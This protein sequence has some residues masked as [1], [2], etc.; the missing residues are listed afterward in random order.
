MAVAM[1][2]RYHQLWA[3]SSP[4]LK[5]FLLT[6]CKRYAVDGTR[7]CNHGV[8]FR[9]ISGFVTWMRAVSQWVT[10]YPVPKKTRK[11]GRTDTDLGSSTST[12][13]EPISAIRSLSPAFLRPPSSLSRSCSHFPRR[14]TTIGS[15]GIRCRAT[16]RD[17][18]DSRSRARQRTSDPPLS[19]PPSSPFC[20]SLFWTSAPP[21]TFSW[22]GE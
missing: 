20:S 7:R 15:K 17:E 1:M 19:P 22:S 3:E 21:S 2:F 16:S 10:V 9:D 6:K 11:R 14:P 12:E 8:T 13:L 5:G 18:R 4:L